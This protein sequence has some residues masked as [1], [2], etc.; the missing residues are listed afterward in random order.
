MERRHFLLASG[1]IAAAG[2]VGA[3][4]W[5]WERV[6]ASVRYPGRLEGHWLRDTSRLP[7][8]SRSMTT[9]VLILGSGIAALTAAWKLYKEGC[10]DFVVVSGPELYGNAAGGRLEAQNYPTGAHY[11][12]LP[13]LESRHV[14]EMLFDLG[15]ILRNP[16]AE[17]PYY[18]ERFLLHAPGERVLYRNQWYEGYE[19]PLSQDGSARSE[20]G[21]FFD[22]IDTLAATRGS[23]GRRLFVIPLEESSADPTWR[24]L[25]HQSFDNWLDSEGFRA[26][27]LRWYLNYCCRDDYGRHAREISA[28]AGLHY[29]CARIGQAENAQ[30][31]AVLTWPEGLSA[32]AQGLGRLAR[33]P[34][35]LVEGTVARLQPVAEG[36]EALCFQ[37]QSGTP[38]AFTVKA[39]R[40][41]LAVP[42]LV[43]AR[44]LP[45]ALELGFDSARDMPRYAP[46]L[47]S[48]FLMNEFPEEKGGE[49]LAWDNVVY[50]ERGLGYVVST[51]QEIRQSRPA[52]SVFSAYNALSDMEPGLGRRWLDTASVPDL[53]EA[54]AADLRLAYGWTLAPCVDRVEITVRGHAMTVPAPGF[55][56]NP[57]LK[58]LRS[59]DGPLLIAHSDLSGLS[60]F[61]EAAWWG[62][63]AAQKILS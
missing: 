61:E 26:E 25:D 37:M 6:P 27:S 11:L 63:R 21:R 16:Y 19:P 34:E 17:R 38:R 15:V 59:L 40:T 29:F 28:W 52:Q 2:A 42:L 58:A 14:R 44:V 8:A 18:D 24:S 56:S 5:Q 4:F 9:D 60:V 47:V 49:P 1:A 13:S 12:P 35:R 22:L 62:Y 50:G 7:Q 41:I 36:M 57:G 23:D 48:N 33:L 32:L 39:R 20:R 3:A 30:R 31:G 55:L 45:N 51:H 43:G 53:L 54:A 10:R 46:W